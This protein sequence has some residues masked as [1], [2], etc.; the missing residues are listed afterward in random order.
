MGYLDDRAL[1]YKNRLDQRNK[2]RFPANKS[3]LIPW[4]EILW[5]TPSLIVVK[6]L[7]G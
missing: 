5:N 6:E 3:D 7:F 2:Q 1:S 4:I